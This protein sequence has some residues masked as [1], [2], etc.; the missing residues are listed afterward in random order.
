MGCLRPATL[1]GNDKHELSRSACWVVA[2]ISIAYLVMAAYT[3]IWLRGRA[4]YDDLL[5]IRHALSLIE[6]H[7]LGPY[8]DLTLAKGPGYPFFLAMGFELGLPVA[9]SH[10]LFYLVACIAMMC[11]LTWVSSGT[12]MPVLLFALLL[13]HPAVLPLRVTRDSIYAPESLLVCAIAILLAWDLRRGLCRMWLA[14]CGGVLF[15]WFCLTR[16]EGIW[17]VPGLLLIASGSAWMSR[18]SGQSLRLL[19]RAMLLFA[20]TAAVVNVS[21]KA[22][23]RIVYGQFVG[24]DFTAS[25]FKDAVAALQG[26]HD[27]ATVPHVPVPSKVRRQAYASSPAFAELEWYLENESS[28]G[29]AW[30][31]WG[32][33]VYPHTCGDFAGGWF[34]WAFRSAVA[35][36]GYYR[37]PRA[38]AAYYRRLTEEIRA[39]CTDGR[40]QCHRS[41]LPLMPQIM[42]AQWREVPGKVADALGVLTFATARPRVVAPPGNAPREGMDRVNRLLGYPLLSGE[43][44]GAPELWLRGWYYA[45]GARWF[46]VRC[47]DGSPAPVKIW[48]RNSPDI[49]SAFHDDAAGRQR[50]E[51]EFGHIVCPLLIVGIGVHD[52]DVTR[53]RSG[54]KRYAFNGET[55]HVDSWKSSASPPA[56]YAVHMAREARRVLIGIYGTVLPVLVTLGAACYLAICALACI[57][58]RS[59]CNRFPLLVVSTLWCMVAAR[60]AVVVMVDVSAFPAIRPLYL[61]PAYPLI[62]AAALCSVFLAFR[63]MP[64][65][66]LKPRARLAR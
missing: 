22:A 46:Q 56:G 11:A 27:G 48:R 29:Y 21:Y 66:R 57:R 12:W 18:K 52:F 2:G 23:N 13:L 9:L 6:G 60:I 5:F 8:G 41:L 25:A 20:L 26:I 59:D 49:A 58:R 32:C 33:Q 34:P 30:R 15:G 4:S 44:T 36:R 38:A 17:M 50:F 19:M 55:L 7:W 47:K 28:P 42:A 24:V 35:S 37:N 53:V 39:A 1:A 45:Q 43:G 61:T 16:E 14:A 40:L 64:W 10:A 51:M 65:R 31:K 3:P 54:Q 63:E 62:C